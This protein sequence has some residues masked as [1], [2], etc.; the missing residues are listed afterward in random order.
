MEI[1]KVIL[2]Y[3]LEEK[4]PLNY[5]YKLRGFFANKFDHVLFHHHKNDGS[6]RYQYPLI[7]YKIIDNIPVIIALQKGCDV[8]TENFLDINKLNIGGKI[9]DY[10]T[11][12]L[13]VDNIRLKV[14][15]DFKMLPYCYSFC[16]PWVALNQKNYKKYINKNKYKTKFLSKIL[17]GNILSFAKGINWWIDKK[18]VVM[19]ELYEID[20]SFKGNRMLAFKGKFYSNILLPELVGLGK[21]CSRGFGTIKRK[22]I[23]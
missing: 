6:L 7:Q 20:V 4:L 9:F 19:P 10:P 2:K 1:R 3:D 23:E 14:I 12:K 15:S 17:I 8:V 22:L 5:G 16:S 18:I 21:L 13:K 11:G